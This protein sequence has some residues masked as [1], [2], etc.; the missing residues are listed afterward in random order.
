MAFAIIKSERM[1]AVPGVSPTV[2]GPTTTKLRTYTAAPVVGVD[3]RVALT[4]HASIVPGM[5]A[6][7]GGLIVRPAVGLRWRF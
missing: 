4:D 7:N 6:L 2:I 5:L 3:A 1:F